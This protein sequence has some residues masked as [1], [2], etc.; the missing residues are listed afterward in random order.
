MCHVVC[1]CH[2]E[3]ETTIIAGGHRL[4]HTKVV[5]ADHTITNIIIF[6]A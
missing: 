5:F 4:C 1:C 6:H 3:E 2:D